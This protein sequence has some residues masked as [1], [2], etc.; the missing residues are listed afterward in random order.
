MSL[1]YDSL[2]NVDLIFSMTYPNSDSFT[3]T[4]F[5]PVGL[6]RSNVVRMVGLW[7]N[8]GDLKDG[9][10]DYLLNRLL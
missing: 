3:Y 1:T 7:Y 6:I 8:G 2:D 4:R 10:G 9:S 5:N